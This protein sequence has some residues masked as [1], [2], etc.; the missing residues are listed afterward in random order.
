VRG[1]EGQVAPASFAEKWSVYF[2]NGQLHEDQV[3]PT[4]LPSSNTF[5]IDGQ[6]LR[7]VDVEH[8][9]THASSFLHVPALD[10]VVGGDIVYGDCYQHLGEANT[11]EKRQQWIDALDQIAALKPSVVVAGHKRASQADGAYLIEAT[12]RYIRDFEEELAKAK[13]PGE[14]E[15]A[16]RRRYP[17]RWNEFILAVSAKMAFA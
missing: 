2:P 6:E 7:A 14:L 16:M 9:D 8:S 5:S 15:E 10:L 13:G 4:A 11:A 17:H 12:K 3:V 1:C